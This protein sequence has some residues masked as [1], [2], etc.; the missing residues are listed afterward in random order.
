MSTSSG[1]VERRHLSRRPLLWAWAAMWPVLSFILVGVGGEFVDRWSPW[2]ANATEERIGASPLGTRYEWPGG[3]CNGSNYAAFPVP[4]PDARELLASGSKYF[5]DPVQA[6]VDGGGA[7]YGNGELTIV[8]S[9]H[10]ASTVL[11]EDIQ[12]VQHVRDERPLEWAAAPMAE[13][14]GGDADVR[15]YRLDLDSPTPRLILTS[16]SGEQR[17]PGPFTPFEVSAQDPTVLIVDVITCTGYQEW[18]LEVAYN[19]SGQAFRTTIGDP[20]SPLRIAGGPAENY[21]EEFYDAGNQQNSWE[22]SSRDKF[23]CPPSSVGER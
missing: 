1:P 7:A 22:E 8:M 11:I 4:A 23:P 2:L 15:Y 10:H 6:V 3:V 5:E 9:A 20:E 19:I 13:C 16:V 21:L 14:G 17:G 12:V 18:G